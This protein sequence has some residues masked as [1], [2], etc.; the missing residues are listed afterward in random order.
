MRL[1][2]PRRLAIVDAERGGRLLSHAGRGSRVLLAG[3]RSGRRCD[4]GLRTVVLAAVGARLRGGAWGQRLQLQCDHAG[5]QLRDDLLGLELRTNL[6]V[7]R[8][9]RDD[10]D[11]NLPGLHV[12]LGRLHLDQHLSVPVIG[13]S[14]I[15]LVG[16][17]DW[18]TR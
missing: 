16:L 18:E 6:H 13:K 7:H 4:D 5:A 10:R 11:R 17:T 8:R 15:R 9:R 1:H 3:D 14:L 12:V 2:L